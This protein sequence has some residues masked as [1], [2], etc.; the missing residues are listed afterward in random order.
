M[1]LVWRSI[2]ESL[3]HKLVTLIGTMMVTPSGIG[4]AKL[5]NHS[6]LSGVDVGQSL[7]IPRTFSYGGKI[8]AGRKSVSASTMVRMVL[9]LTR[10]FSR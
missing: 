6:A 8:H 3:I 9:A 10:F 1:K 5:E 2:L 7:T 4:W